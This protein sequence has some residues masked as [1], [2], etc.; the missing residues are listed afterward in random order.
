MA[1]AEGK[2]DKNAVKVQEDWNVNWFASN[3]LI[4]IVPVLANC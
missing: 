2:E 3:T 1:V 4:S